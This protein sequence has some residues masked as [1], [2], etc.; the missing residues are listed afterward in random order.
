ML[1]TKHL[2]DYIELDQVPVTLMTLSNYVTQVA[3]DA[4]IGSFKLYA[5]HQE[6][7]N[8]KINMLLAEQQEDIIPCTPPSA[9]LIHSS[10]EVNTYRK[11]NLLGN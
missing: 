4:L 1:P 10:A 7:P 9:K 11:I 8:L 2:K 3:K 6:T 5:N